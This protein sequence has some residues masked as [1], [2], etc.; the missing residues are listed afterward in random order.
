MT[1][2]T[3]LLSGTQL[4][5]ATGLRA[6]TPITVI[7]WAATTRQLPL[8]SIPPSR[9]LRQRP[10]LALCALAA[11]GEFVGDKLPIVPPRTA[12]ASLTV[13][14]GLGTTVGA[15]SGTGSSQT[16]FLGGVAGVVGAACGAY[17]GTA[18][19]QAFAHAGVPDAAVAVLEDCLAIA[20]AIG[21]FLRLRSAVA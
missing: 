15:I 12:L 21:A 4:G 13:R 1:T 5:V 7:A 9:L 11:A 16:L 18:A 8:P 10:V 19:R 20:L 14:M 17:A 2:T 3:S 6:F